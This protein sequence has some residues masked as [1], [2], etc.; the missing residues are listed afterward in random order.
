MAYRVDPEIITTFKGIRQL[1]GINSG[2]VISAIQCNNVELIPTE[3]GAECGI[4]TMSGNK[5]VYSLP[6]GYKV[7]GIFMSEQ[8]GVQYKFIY[9]ENT[10]D[11][12]LF[13]V[14]SSGQVEQVP[15]TP[16]FTLSGECNGMTMRS[17]AYDVFVFTNGKKF[18]VESNEY[19]FISVCFTSGEKLLSSIDFISPFSVSI[20]ALFLK[21]F[22][23]LLITFPAPS[24]SIVEGIASTPAIKISLKY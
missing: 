18:S 7:M 12:K 13:Y 20:R 10:T 16:T 5:L 21:M 9:G 2:G 23:P 1:N 3:I 22:P 6:S 4:K 8:D 14:N 24:I 17:S 19:S 11:G 15:D